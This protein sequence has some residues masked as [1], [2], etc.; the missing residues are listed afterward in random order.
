MAEEARAVAARMKNADLR[1]ELLQ[2]ARGY[3]AL[4]KLAEATTDQHSREDQ[5]PPSS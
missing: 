4:A 3:E 1:R 2:I 5:A